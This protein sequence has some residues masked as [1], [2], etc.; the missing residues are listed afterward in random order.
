MT[1]LSLYASQILAEEHIAKLHELA[2]NE[3]QL[4]ALRR[5]QASDRTRARLAWRLG[6]RQPAS[7]S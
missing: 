6:R 1:A 4:K 5:R 3:H 2:E 7:T